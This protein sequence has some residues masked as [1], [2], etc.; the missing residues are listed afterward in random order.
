[1]TQRTRID[2]SWHAP[3]LGEAPEADG[4]SSTLSRPTYTNGLEPDIAESAT[5]SSRAIDA[6]ARKG[7]VVPHGH[8]EPI[9][10]MRSWNR[11]GSTSSRSLLENTFTD[12][13]WTV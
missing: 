2:S 13:K 3:L 11:L 4:T 12:G 7:P 9:A 10:H 5:N 1:M 6:P 8:V